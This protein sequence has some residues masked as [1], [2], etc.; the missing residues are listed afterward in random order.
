MVIGTFY[1]V[2]KLTPVTLA[3][4]PSEARFF[5]L[6]DIRFWLAQSILGPSGKRIPFAHDMLQG[7][8]VAFSW[9]RG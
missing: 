1:Q 4:V 5:Y 2:L 6:P 3:Q 8:P 7:P 9:V